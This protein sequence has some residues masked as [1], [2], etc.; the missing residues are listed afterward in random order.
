MLAVALCCP[1]VSA[2]MVVSAHDDDMWTLRM[3]RWAGAAARLMARWRAGHRHRCHF[4]YRE[5]HGEEQWQPD[6]KEFHGRFEVARIL[7]LATVTRSSGNR[8]LK[9]SSVVLRR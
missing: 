5:Q 6:A 2:G 4:P 7:K 8:T 9:M 1:R 3:T